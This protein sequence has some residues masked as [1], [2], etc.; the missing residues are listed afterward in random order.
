MRTVG[1]APPIYVETLIRAPLDSLWTHTQ[2]PELHQQWDL[3][4]SRIAYLPRPDPAAPQRFYE[5]PVGF[6]FPMLFL[7][8]AGVCE[9]YSE[10]TDRFKIDVRVHNRAW[11]DLFGYRGSFEVAYKA[12]DGRS[13]PAHVRP[14]REERRE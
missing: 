3:R 6:N 11:G 10:A 8:I 9:W 12:L 1:K 5:G 13:I 4:F 14:L 7:G 2:T